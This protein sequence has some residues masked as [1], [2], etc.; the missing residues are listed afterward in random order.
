MKLIYAPLSRVIAGSAFG[1]VVLSAAVQAG[2][3][4]LA[5]TSKKVGGA[6]SP[7][8]QKT[9]CCKVVDPP[10][11]YKD[12]KNPYIQQFSITHRYQG[13]YYSTDANT[14]EDDD[15]DNRR[16]RL[17]AEI[18]F[19]QQFALKGQFN[20]NTDSSL[21]G[22]F[23]QN[24]DTLEVE[25]APRDEWSVVVGKQKPG[26]T[27]EYS[28]SSA[29]ILTFERSLLVNQITPDKLGGISVDYGSGA[30]EANLGVFSGSVDDD[31]ELPDFE[32][33]FGVLAKFGYDVTDDINIGLHYMWQDEDDENDG[34][35][36]Y[37]HLVSLNS[38]NKWRNVGLQTDLI[39]AIGYAGVSDV[40][41]L[42]VLPYYDINDGLRLVA[43]YQ[44][45]TAD[46]SDGLRLQSRYERPAVEDGSSTRGDDYHAIYAGLNWYICGE[47]LKLMTGIEWSG[48]G[49]KA[50]YDGYTFFTGVRTNF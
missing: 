29:K 27:K 50:D 32:G 26:I 40:F 36:D 18:K 17:G 5:D 13:Q 38:D 2:E 33:S 31:Y 9:L 39:Y 35:A 6:P 15:W 14:G 46:S 21:A 47:N 49:G 44:Y 42:V 19:L 7:F 30:I 1:A 34:F 10:A 22:R 48:L 16:W 11:L 8:E 25:W 23:F 20:L 4:M 43:R 45:A 28:T 24:V 41:G 12:E 3:V 37:E